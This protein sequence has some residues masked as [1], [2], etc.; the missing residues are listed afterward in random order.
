VAEREHW[1]SRTSFVLAAIGSAIGLGNV[2][3]FPYVCYANGG[4][5]FIIPYLVALLTAGIPLLILEMGLGHKFAAS[6][7]IAMQGTGK[8]REWIGWFACGVGFMIVAYYSVIMG[9]C[10]NY[11][12]YSF[13]LAWG[14]NTESFFYNDFLQRSQNM[15]DIFT[16]NGPVLIG[17]L[18]SWVLIILC[19]WKGAKSVGKV[20]YFTVPLPWLCLVIF[21]IKGLTLPGAED[22]I[23]YYLTPN[24]QMLSD[25]KV[26]LHAYGQI[27]FSLSVG[28]GVMMAYASFLPK[29]SDIVNNA[30]IVALANNGTSFLGGFAVF[31]TLGYY[32][33]QTGVPVQSVVDCG[34]GLAFITYP[35]IINHLGRLAPVMGA[36]FFIMLMTLAI[37]SAFSLVEGVAAG[38]M[39]KWNARRLR[40]NLG[41]GIVAMIIGVTYTTRAGYYWLDVVDYF[42]NNFG[43]V[44]VCL[45]ECIAIGYFYGTGKLR[46]YVNSQSEV[47]IGIWWDIMIM[48]VTPAALIYTL[49]IEIKD[50]VAQPYGAPVV[51]RW[52]EFAGGWAVIALLV[53][54]SVAL[55]R[56]RGRRTA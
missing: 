28:F 32:A 8:N 18:I 21:V 10:V 41:L 31:S 11:F 24:F 19:I 2:W 22:G 55:M 4:G 1:P 15:K 45:L 39:D 53:I 30:F 9:W 16:L 34:F 7:P 25:P 13:S 27:F 12:G 23:A 35:S 3:R 36:L 54:V 40:V 38:F 50:R 26:W 17:L 20:V 29:R 5:A 14:H 47:S 49:I 46:R 44:L 48:F 6:T 56:A 37:D 33:K 51:E 52:A 43:L 42:M